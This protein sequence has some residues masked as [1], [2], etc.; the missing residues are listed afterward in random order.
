MKIFISADMEG[1]TGIT[2]IEQCES[3]R[4]EYAFGRLM[5]RHDVLAAVRGAL[6]GG[7][8]EVIV[9]DA[10][11]H[12]TNLEIVDWPKGATLI[13]GSPKTLGMMEG[14]DL[15][16]GVFFLCYHGMAGAQNAV[17][18]HTIDPL[19]AYSIRLN[20]LEVGETGINAAAAAGRNIPVALVTGDAAVCSEALSQLGG[21]LT[22]AAV[23][24]GRGRLAAE[25]LPPSETNRIIY[26]AAIRAAQMVAKRKA[27]VFR[28]KT[29]WTVEIDF[30]RTAQCDAAATL[31]F[32]ERLSGR[33]VRFIGN[34]LVE[35]RRYIS[36]ILDLAGTARF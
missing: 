31:P 11:N 36:A 25:C 26:E 4:P 23:K 9:N 17:L 29:P 24:K 10:H 19:V 27:P 32:I 28:A 8:D 6:D 3:D 33:T 30:L 14:F 34:D 2:A 22:T 35:M 13:S 7:A 18:D 15:C 5:Q 20:G 16:D 1:A 21:N 12:M